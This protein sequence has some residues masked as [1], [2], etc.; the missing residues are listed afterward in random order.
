[1]FNGYRVLE[2]KG[3]RK[4]NER[5][6]GKRVSWGLWGYYVKERS[7]HKKAHT[8]PHNPPSGDPFSRVSLRFSVCLKT[9]YMNLNA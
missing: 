7:A 1:M 9:D 8:K 4:G 6:M 3:Y 5:T 2:F